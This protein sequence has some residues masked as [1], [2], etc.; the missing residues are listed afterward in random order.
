M[1]RYCWQK[2]G[3]LYGRTA[4]NVVW[5]FK[6]G[7]R[8][9]VTFGVWEHTGVARWQA[10]VRSRAR[11]AGHVGGRPAVRKKQAAVPV[12]YS[13]SRLLVTRGGWSRLALFAADEWH[14]WRDN[15]GHAE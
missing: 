3:T 10:H 14:R 2:G 9:R 7:H 4:R 1:P 5:G 12:R 13:V 6:E 11:T 15:G 8:R